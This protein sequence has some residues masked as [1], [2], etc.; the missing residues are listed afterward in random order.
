MLYK[1]KNK[2]ENDTPKWKKNYKQVKSIIFV[3][4]AFYAEIAQ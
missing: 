2:L 1:E 3:I 4:C